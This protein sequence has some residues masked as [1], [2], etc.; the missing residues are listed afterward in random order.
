MSLIF[1]AIAIFLYTPIGDNEQVKKFI[2][3]QESVLGIIFEDETVYSKSFSEE[4]WNKIHVGNTVKDV[5]QLVGDPLEK[6]T[7]NVEQQYWYYS[8]PSPKNTNYHMRIIVF[9]SNNKVER[10]IKE[11]YLD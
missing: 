8:K 10:M 6:N 4:N 3:S 7:E 1:L 11:F 9:N 2:L 5:V